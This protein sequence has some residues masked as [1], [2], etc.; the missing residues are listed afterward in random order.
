MCKPSSVTRPQLQDLPGRACSI[1]GALEVV[2]ERW[3]L[4]VVREVSM[5]AHRFTDI[6][7]GTGAPRD[8]LAARLATL[9][10]LGVLERRAYSTAPPRSTYHLTRSG[11]DL[12]PV[13]HALLAWG[14]RWVADEPPVVLRHHDHPIDM[15]WVC[16]TCG[17]PVSASP[18]ERV[19]TPAGRALEGLPPEDD[20]T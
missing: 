5:G 2:G 16:R 18:V 9:V 1:A 7:R 3:A 19:L 10:E 17:E 15:A 4:L 13:L 11:R 12:I 14:D 8:R 20:E 6:A